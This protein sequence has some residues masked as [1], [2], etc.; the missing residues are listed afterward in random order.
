MARAE[1]LGVLTAAQWALNVAMNANPIGLVVA[2]IAALV[3]G[4]VW[5][6]NTFEGFRKA[7][8]IVWEFLKAFAIGVAKAFWGL[9]ETIVGALTLNPSLIKK[10]LE[11]T[12][13]AVRDTIK[14]ISQAGEKGAAPGAA[15]WAKSNK[16]LVPSK[17][18]ATKT[19]TSEN[20]GTVAAP[21]TKAEGKK[22]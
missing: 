19:T 9:G 11:D 18:I 17:K 21:K 20:N 12:V 4:V 1:G 10:G 22:I 7:V 15:S 14:E 5:A 6:W 8:Y 3:A 16:S 2:G 13:S